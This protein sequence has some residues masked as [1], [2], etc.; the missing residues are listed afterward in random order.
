MHLIPYI[1]W[2]NVIFHVSVRCMHL[3]ENV[4]GPDAEEFKPERWINSNGDF[5]TRS[6][7]LPFGLGM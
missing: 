4:W 6:E 5:E 2:I 3:D 1:D 7:F